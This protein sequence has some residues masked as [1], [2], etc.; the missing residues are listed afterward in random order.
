MAAVDRDDFVKPRPCMF[1]GMLVFLSRRDL[2]DIGNWFN[3]GL[4]IWTVTAK[5]GRRPWLTPDQ[6]QRTKFLLGT[7]L[8]TDP[9]RDFISQPTLDELIPTIF[10][11]NE[12]FKEQYRGDDSSDLLCTEENNAPPPQEL[13]IGLVLNG[14]FDDFVS[15]VG[16]V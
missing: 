1:F 6:Y 16:W 3:C 11:R 10:K 2:V 13:S 7:K 5:P 15:K 4:I 8:R 14:G 12:N 9:T